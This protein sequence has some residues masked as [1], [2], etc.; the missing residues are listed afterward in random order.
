MIVWIQRH[1]FSYEELPISTYQQA[2]DAFEEFDW[3]EEIL[4]EK[5]LEEE[6]CPPGFGIVS[7]DG[8]VL[9]LVP[10]ET[11]ECLIHFHYPHT[12]KYLFIFTRNL[13]KTITKENASWGESVLL[14]EQMFHADLDKI[15]TMV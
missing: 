12:E 14:M 13:K 9:H 2:V 10:K 15:L 1:D 7:D 5:E 6:T 3:A 8:H 4:K 11:G